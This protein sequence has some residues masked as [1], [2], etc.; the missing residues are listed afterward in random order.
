[1]ANR[2]NRRKVNHKGRNNKSSRFSMWYHHIGESAAYASLD[3]TARLLLLELQTLFN[4]SNNGSIYLSIRDA[5]ARLSLSDFRPAERAFEDLQDRGFI[6]L[7]K[8]A[9]FQSGSSGQ[10]K[11][12][13][14]RL[15]WESWPEC[16]NRRKRIPTHDYRN[17][18]PAPGK[19]AK[20]ADRR[21]RALAAYRKGMATGKFPVVESTTLEAQMDVRDNP[22]VGE[23]TT[24]ISGNGQISLVVDVVDSTAHIDDT[25]GMA[26]SPWW[27]SDAERQIWGKYLLY[28]WAIQN[29]PILAEAA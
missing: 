7:A 2:P 4:G 17:Y 14:W 20:R 24:E 15:T 18:Q 27:Q 23:T 29:R 28:T 10:S 3:G 1:M 9:K 26:A 21:L 8:D 25:R 16:P 5:T 6:I 13:C 11:A 22:S 19:A 12:R